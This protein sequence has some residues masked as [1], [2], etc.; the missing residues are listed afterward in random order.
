[1]SVTYPGVAFPDVDFPRMS[2]GDL[3]AAA[4]V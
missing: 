1:M 2:T 3:H 4:T